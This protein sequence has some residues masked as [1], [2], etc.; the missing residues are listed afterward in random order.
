MNV[1]EKVSY[2]DWNGSALVD[3]ERNDCIVVDDST[4]ALDDGKWYVVSDD[5]TVPECIMVNG[6][7]HLILKD[8]MPGDVSE[9][10]S[11]YIYWAAG[12]GIVNGYS[13]GNFGRL[14]NCTRNQFAVMIWKLM[15][16]EEAKKD[17]G[18][19]FADLDEGTAVAWAYENG[20]IGGTEK[21]GKLYFNPGDNITRSQLVTILW[22][23]AGAPVVKNAKT[24]FTDVKYPNKSITW[25]SK[26]KIVQGF[27]DGT[28][29][30][31]AY[32]SRQQIATM[33][34]KF[35]QKVLNK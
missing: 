22:K 3:A 16:S 27:S 21:N 1:P 12:E 34:Y 23:I 17:A 24:Q 35:S 4:T 8:V 25:A 10:K 30:P 15:G 9:S 7:A 19:Y 2:I 31:S 6:D 28:F 33:L 26:L 5:V 18:E 14:D 13:D 32:T 11:K 29:K 20:I